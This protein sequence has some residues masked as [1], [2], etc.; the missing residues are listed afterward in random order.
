M[1]VSGFLSR[2]V[3]M[4]F[5]CWVQIMSIHKY[6]GS[7]KSNTNALIT[8]DFRITDLRYFVIPTHL[9]IYCYELHCRTLHNF[10]WV[11]LQELNIV[12][13]SSPTVVIA[14]KVPVINMIVISQNLFGVILGQCPSMIS[15]KSCDKAQR[16]V[17]YVRFCQG[18]EI[19]L[20]QKKTTWNILVKNHFLVISCT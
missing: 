4:L 17:I 13:P 3:S 15:R 1:Y 2:L 18:H 6:S 20:L 11:I 12:F 14:V 19:K 8:G 5:P 16:N 7:F 9:I 10:L